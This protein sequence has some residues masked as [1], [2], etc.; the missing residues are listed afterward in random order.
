MVFALW[1]PQR[2]KKNRAAEPKEMKVQNLPWLL[3]ELEAGRMYFKAV[4][5]LLGK[6]SIL[7]NLKPGN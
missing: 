2:E 4:K 1:K 6:L 3:S 7:Y 5:D